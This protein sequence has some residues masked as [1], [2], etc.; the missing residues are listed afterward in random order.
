[1][2]RLDT[3]QEESIPFSEEVP[4]MRFGTMWAHNTTIY[5]GPSD[6]EAFPLLRNGI[7]TNKTRRVPTSG[8]WTYNT[9]NLNAGWTRLSDLG[10]N[11]TFYPVTA[12]SVAYSDGTAYIM[13]GTY[14]LNTTLKNPDGTLMTPGLAEVQKVGLDSLFRLDMKTNVGTNET[15]EMGP[16][17]SG[18][19]V[20]IKSA[21]KNG[22][23]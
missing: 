5:L 21:G 9:A 13:G 6:L 4:R 23:K 15:T 8:I 22:S 20:F 12:G 2:S 17:N 16:V 3:V 10:H 1:M 18:R 14:S 11:S 7:W 19:M